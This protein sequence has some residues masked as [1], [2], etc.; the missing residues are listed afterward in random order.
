LRRFFNA[1]IAAIAAIFPQFFNAAVAAIA[2]IAAI[3]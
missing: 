3:L 1:P 2:A